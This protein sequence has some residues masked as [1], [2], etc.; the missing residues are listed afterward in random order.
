MGPCGPCARPATCCQL[1]MLGQMQEQWDKGAKLGCVMGV[2]MA[3]S[4]TGPPVLCVMCAA[5]GASPQ[6]L[7]AH[8]DRRR[9]GGG[10]KVEVTGAP[11]LPHK[12]RLSRLTG[13]GAH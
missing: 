2:L 1:A 8:H 11:N 10:D 7:S 4:T 9:Q 6:G 12:G 13:Q 5:G 3:V